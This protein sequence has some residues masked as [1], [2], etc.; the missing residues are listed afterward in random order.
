[1]KAWVLLNSGF[2]N[3]FVKV[4]YCLPLTGEDSRERK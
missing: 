3:Y 1:M 2:W 4:V